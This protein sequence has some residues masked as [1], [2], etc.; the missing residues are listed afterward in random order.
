MHPSIKKP[1]EMAL[2]AIKSQSKAVQVFKKP[3]IPVKKKEKKIILDEDSY[4][5]VRNQ[6]DCKYFLKIEANIFNN[7]FNFRSSAKSF[8]AISSPTSKS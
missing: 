4:M 8:S 3:S 1:G 7:F 2:V 5:K 6:N